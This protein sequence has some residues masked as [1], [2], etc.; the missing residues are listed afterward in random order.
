MR[1]VLGQGKIVE[2]NFHFYLRMGKTLSRW[3]IGL[4]PGGSR[5]LGDAESQT[6][7]IEKPVAKRPAG[8][9]SAA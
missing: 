7:L 3:N 2:E 1:T 5:F 8:I 4:T 6:R 9:Q